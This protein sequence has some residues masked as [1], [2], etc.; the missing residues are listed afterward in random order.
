[1][2]LIEKQFVVNVRLIFGDIRNFYRILKIMKN[3][4]FF[5]VNIN[6]F[7]LEIAF[8]NCSV[9]E[10]QSDCVEACTPWCSDSVEFAC[11]HIYGRSVFNA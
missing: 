4:H 8:E 2:Y 9:T 11:H 10:G 7:D 5:V 1:L 6:L 3:G